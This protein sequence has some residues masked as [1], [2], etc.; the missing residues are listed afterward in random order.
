MKRNHLLLTALAASLTIALSGCVYACNQSW[1]D[2][3]PLTSVSAT[4]EPTTDGGT[5]VAKD[6]DAATLAS[7]GSCCTVDVEAT[8]WQKLRSPRRRIIV[9]ITGSTD[10]TRKSSDQARSAAGR[11][12]GALN[13]SQMAWRSAGR[14]REV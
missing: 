10:F 14:R 4:H 2:L 1:E 8:P 3:R 6:E 12:A 5:V 7:A 9:W 11:P 13:R